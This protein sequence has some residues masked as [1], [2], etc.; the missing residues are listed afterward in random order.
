MTLGDSP[1]RFGDLGCRRATAPDDRD[2]VRRPG[3][4]RGPPAISRSS[5]ST[6]RSATT[7]GC[8]RRCTRTRRRATRDRHAVP[9]DGGD[10]PG[11]RSGG[12]RPADGGGFA[13]IALTQLIRPG[14]RCCSARSS[15]RS[16]CSR[17]RPISAVRVRRRPLRDGS[18][19]PPVRPALARR[20]RRP[21]VE[22][23]R[24]RPGGLRVLQ[25]DAARVPRR[26]QPRHARRRLARVGPRREL[27]QVHPRP[28]DPA[29]I[30]LAEFT[31]LVV[32][33]ASLAFDAHLEWATAATSSAPRT[34]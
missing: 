7:T 6:R 3:G 28:R 21:D 25:H 20:R 34:P 14:R 31:P 12:D 23:V 15:R 2:P 30:L 5:T 22:P 8:S 24:R 19:R 17:A 10:G 4:D 18:D 33:E 27:R 26:R 16:T 13:G 1:T 11:H 9:A 32:D 29:D